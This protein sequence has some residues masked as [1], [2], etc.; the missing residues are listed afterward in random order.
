MNTVNVPQGY[1]TVM[2]YLIV[3]DAE[4]LMDFLK[5][6]FGAAEKMVVP[7]DKGEIMHAEVTIGDSCIM[8]ANSTEQFSVQNA[9]LYIHVADA[10]T[11][12]KAALQAGATSVMQPENRDYGRSGG[13]K[14][15]WGNT[16][17]VTT[18]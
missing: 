8:L 10:D 13:V 16:W 6:V 9:G 2:P 18:S 15:P 3:A 14:D 17:W 5:K 4:G 7:D 1:N 12:Y 11:A